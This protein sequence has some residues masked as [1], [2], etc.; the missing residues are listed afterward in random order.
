MNVHK[1]RKSY[2]RWACRI[3]VV[4]LLFLS[5][6]CNVIHSRNKVHEA[7]PDADVRQVFLGANMNIL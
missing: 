1:T 5:S 2:V 6:G 3:L 4:A 7:F